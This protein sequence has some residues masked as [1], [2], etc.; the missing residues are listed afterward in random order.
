MT[1]K[2][3]SIAAANKSLARREKQKGIIAGYARDITQWTHVESYILDEVSEKYECADDVDKFGK[4]VKRK[5]GLTAAILL[6]NIRATTLNKYLENTGSSG[7]QECNVRLLEFHYALP[8]WSA[9]TGLSVGELRGA[10]QTL[11]AANKITVEDAPRPND[12]NVVRLNPTGLLDYWN[13]PQEFAL[14]PEENEDEAAK[15]VITSKRYNAVSWIFINGITINNG[16]HKYNV[17]ATK[18]VNDH[19]RVRYFQIEQTL[20]YG[21]AAGILLHNLRAWLRSNLKKQTR[22]ALKYGWLFSFEDYKY[23]ASKTGLTYDQVKKNFHKLEN[24]NIL[25]IRRGDGGVNHYTF[26]NFETE[27]LVGVPE[28]KEKTIILDLLKEH[29]LLKLMPDFKSQKAQR[30][31]EKVKNKIDVCSLAISAFTSEQ[32]KTELD[33]SL[34]TSEALQEAKFARL[35]SDFL[36]NLAGLPEKAKTEIVNNAN[37]NPQTSHSLNLD[38][39]LK[40]EFTSEQLAARARLFARSSVAVN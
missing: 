19:K 29:D 36:I 4:P 13:Y 23:W 14:Y 7:A 33:K 10:F 5:L 20:K 11:Q 38:G 31:A 27:L 24:L 26:S 8:E 37:Y 30:F 18:R 16:T 9:V 39:T 34:M 22:G 35:A 25:K 3:E 15:N 40:F 17:F 12:P 2:E 28:E 32:T 21:L 1:K 6:Q